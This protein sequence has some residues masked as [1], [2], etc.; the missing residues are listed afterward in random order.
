MNHLLPEHLIRIVWCL[1]LPVQWRSQE[2]LSIGQF[3][4]QTILRV[5][6]PWA[7]EKSSGLQFFKISSLFQSEC[8]LK[9]KIN[10]PQSRD[11]HVRRFCTTSQRYLFF[12][13]E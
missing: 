11:E 2:F 1:F 6:Q 7:I 13:S 9:R 3:L 5:G 4:S 10:N 12:Q 8:L